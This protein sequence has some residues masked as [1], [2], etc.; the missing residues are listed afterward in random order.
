MLYT[1]NAYSFSHVNHNLIKWLKKWLSWKVVNV[2][3][4]RHN[5]GIH[6][7]RPGK[8]EGHVSPLSRQGK[9]VPGPAGSSKELRFTLSAT[10][11]LTC[12]LYARTSVAFCELLFF[13]TCSFS[14]ALAPAS[15][16]PA[17][18]I[19]PGGIFIDLG[20]QWRPLSPASDACIKPRLH[21]P[22][23][24]TPGSSDV[25]K[26]LQQHPLSVAPPLLSSSANHTTCHADVPPGN[27]VL[28]ISV[29]VIPP[30]IA[31]SPSI[32]TFS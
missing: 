11:S 7:V 24:C 18:L 16:A 23:A 13:C 5:T 26:S 25:C 14:V 4:N 3:R 20:W 29:S 17:L 12:S 1:L 31:T 21:P 15:L 32:T 22:S 6:L 27:L 10:G 30:L 19:L 28:T 2:R 9:L 8:E